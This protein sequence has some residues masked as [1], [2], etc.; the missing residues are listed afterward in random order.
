MMK[1]RKDIH[2]TQ[3]RVPEIE[4]NHGNVYI[5]SNIRRET[6]EG[7][8]G[9]TYNGWIYDEWFM[10]ESD[11]VLIQMGSMPEGG[12]WDCTLRSVERS[13]LYRKADDMIAKYSTDVPNEAMRTNWIEYKHQ[14]RMTQEAPGYPRTVEYPE[15]P[16]E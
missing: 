4:A 2:G 9:V 11:Y 10:S 16:G 6:Y 5:R 3:T 12:I 14:V 15:E 8:D 1:F 7:D 13:M